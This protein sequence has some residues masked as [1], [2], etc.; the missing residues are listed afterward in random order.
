MKLFRFDSDSSRP[1]DLYGSRSLL[2]SG[3]ARTAADTRVDVMH[4]GADGLVGVHEAQANQ[5][6]AVVQGTGWVRGGTGHQVQVNAGIAAFLEAGERHESGSE[7][8]MT[9]VAIEGPE[10]DPAGLIREFPAS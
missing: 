9:V 10:V 7:E 4:I 3:L 2:M 6:F 1:I 8:G 5:I